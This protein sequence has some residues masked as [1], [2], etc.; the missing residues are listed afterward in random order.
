MFTKKQKQIDK[1]FVYTKKT[2]NGNTG[3]VPIVL[4]KK[5]NIYVKLYYLSI[6]FILYNFNYYLNNINL[7][8]QYLLHRHKVRGK[9]GMWWWVGVTPRHRNCSGHFSN[10]TE[11][12]KF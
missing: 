4:Y 6:I 7:K 8:I 2:N 11:L 3:K 5:Q 9:W 12:F 1:L 10:Q